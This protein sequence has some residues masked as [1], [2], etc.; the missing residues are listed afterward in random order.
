MIWCW[1]WV[2]A[3]CAG[4]PGIGERP[5]SAV[6]PYL[7]LYRGSFETA[8][9]EDP[10]DD[11]NYN[12]CEPT[13]GQECLTH[14]APLT[15]ILLEL[16]RDADGQ[17]RLTFFRTGE[18]LATRR[19]LDL[20]GRGCG[21]RLGG[22]AS[23]ES[24]DGHRGAVATFPLTA[25]NRI[26]LGKLRPVSRHHVRLE[27]HPGAAESKREIDVVI[28]RNVRDTNYLYVVED[29]VRRRVRIDLDNTLRGDNG[30]RYRV[31]IEDDLGEYGRCVLTDREFRSFALPVPVPGGVAVNYTWWQELRPRL[32]RT[33][34]RY[35]VVRYTG[36]FEPV[37][38]GAF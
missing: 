23:L 1:P 18:D 28:D 26:C 25:E 2:A 15:E 21:T 19:P 17:V 31:C 32:H 30:D 7:G 24:A 38:P 36:R 13:S 33:R 8:L 12:P 6:E 29:G 22:L 20:L 14:H 4:L 37:V 34:G 35:E 16:R 10:A 9:T 27:L 5:Q 11:L 3:A